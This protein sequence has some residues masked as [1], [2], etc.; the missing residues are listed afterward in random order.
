MA[1]FNK[2]ADAGGIREDDFDKMKD[3]I[4]LSQVKIVAFTDY[5]PNWPLFASP[6]LD[7]GKAAKIKAA[8]LKLKPGDPKSVTVVDAAKLVG[9]APVND[10]EYDQLRSAAKL[11]GAL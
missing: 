3:K 6:N 2:A 7:K 5:Y 8:L 4:D 9:F 11:V 1:V 10:K